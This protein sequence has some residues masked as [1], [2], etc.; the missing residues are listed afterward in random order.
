[1]A[2]GTCLS[3]RPQLLLLD[4]KMPYLSGFEVLEWLS[5][6][7]EYRDLPVVMLSS[8]AN[9]SDIARALELGARDYLVKPVGMH[10]L[11]DLL[12]QVREKYLTKPLAR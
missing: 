10:Q 2:D 1:M 9:E 4:V 3:E 11:T 7:A 5:S 8:S 12:K 6:H